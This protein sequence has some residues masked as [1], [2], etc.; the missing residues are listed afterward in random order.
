MARA[1]MPQSSQSISKSEFE[2]HGHGKK[3]AQLLRRLNIKE[4]NY[5]VPQETE[6]GMKF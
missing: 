4:F 5:A 2:H 1:V 3:F 6:G